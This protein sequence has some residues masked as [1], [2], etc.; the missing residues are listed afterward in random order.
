[1]AVEATAS[2][3]DS[4]DQALIAEIAPAMLAKLKLDGSLY[5]Y[6]ILIL[7]LTIIPTLS[8]PGSVT[9]FIA[10][11]L[12]LGPDGPRRVADFVYLF[13]VFGG[14]LILPWYFKRSSV[15]AELKYRRR[16]GKWRWE[17]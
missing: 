13:A 15:R 5:G 16:H 1:M 11:A 6:L 7:G 10:A 14:C 12:R 2:S 8:F 4:T 9:E 17:A 3:S